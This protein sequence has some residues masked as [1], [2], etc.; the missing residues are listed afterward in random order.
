VVAPT[1]DETAA[2]ARAARPFS[3][4]MREV[5]A[6]YAMSLQVIVQM[7]RPP[8]AWREFVE[9]TWFVARVSTLPALAL[10]ISFI[11]VIQYLLTLLLTSLGAKDLGGVGAS[12]VVIN[13][14]GPLSTASV[15]CGAG[16]TAMCADL[17]SRTIREELDAMRTMGIDPIQRLV[18]PRVVALTVVAT[19]LQGIVAVTGLASA[20]AFAV[21][22]QGTVPGA[23]ATTLTLL[24]G[25]TGVI[26]SF[27]KAAIFGFIGALVACYK[28]FYPAPGPAGV[29]SAVN[30]TVVFAFVADFAAFAIIAAIEAISMRAG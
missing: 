4:A 1:E 21:Y 15:V 27:A 9:Q 26:W 17:G 24:T 7:V 19:L 11:T 13:T 23:F 30:E 2:P 10:G 12:V 5:G 14:V 20:Y 29:G 8:F 16:A 3:K 22:V 28:G 6:F 18:V 25:T